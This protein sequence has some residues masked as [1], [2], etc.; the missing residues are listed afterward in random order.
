MNCILGC[1][2]RLLTFKYK[3][4][5]APFIILLKLLLFIC[6]IMDSESHCL[7]HFVMIKIFWNFGIKDSNFY[8]YFG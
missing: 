4:S 2:F 5:F 8:F 1:E 3:R 6:Y 7:L